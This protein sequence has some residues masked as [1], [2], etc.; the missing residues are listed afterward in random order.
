MRVL[1]WVCLYH[2]YWVVSFGLVGVHGR[3]Y[4]LSFCWG[5][6]WVPDIQNPPLGRKGCSFFL[7]FFSLFLS[8][9]IRDGG[10]H[11]H[12]DD[13]LFFVTAGEEVEYMIP[14]YKFKS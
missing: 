10:R 8:L 11:Q 4:F 3:S 6:V 13:P 5:A 14:L 1:I 12:H 7:P 2:Y 9:V